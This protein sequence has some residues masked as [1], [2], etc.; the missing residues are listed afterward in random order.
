MP[1]VAPGKKG[2]TPREIGQGPVLSDQELRAVN[3][4]SI[5]NS[6]LSSLSLP[7]LRAKL[8]ERRIPLPGG[9]EGPLSLA[10]LST[11]GSGWLWLSGSGSLLP[12]GLY[13]NFGTRV[14]ASTQVGAWRPGLNGDCRLLSP[15]CL[16]PGRRL[17]L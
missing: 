15:F 17:F 4:N 13:Q 5:S 12:A 3:L 10:G 14:R 2:K 8:F 16:K 11:L 9:N 6:R 1:G 7:F